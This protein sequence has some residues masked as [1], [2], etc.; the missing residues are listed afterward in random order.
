[1][2]C[3]FNT[4]WFNKTYY[5][6]VKPRRNAL[7]GI[8][9]ELPIIKQIDVLLVINFFFYYYLFVLLFLTTRCILF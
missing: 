1:M 8:N 7:P 2:T 6:R 9:F 3:D 5:C 4:E